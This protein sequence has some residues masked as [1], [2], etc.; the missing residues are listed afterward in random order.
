MIKIKE[1]PE[2]VTIEEIP[3][4]QWIGFFFL[5]LFFLFYLIFGFTTFV[6]IDITLNMKLFLS[7]WSLALSGVL[8]FVFCPS[9]KIKIN[10]QKKS[11]II[12]KKSLIKNDSSIYFFNQIGELI[13]V[14]AKQGSRGG[15]SYQLILPLKNGEKIEISSSIGSKESQYYKTAD[16]INEYIFDDPNQVSY[17]LTLF[18]DE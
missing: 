17:K 9:I 8:V 12:Y 13:F 3:F 1:N 18:H 2:E 14:N 15:M 6:G 10:K 4:S 5:F 16:L 7:F 11:I